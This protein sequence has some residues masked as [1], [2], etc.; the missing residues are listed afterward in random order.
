M[1]TVWNQ[2]PLGVLGPA[3]TCRGCDHSLWR[4]GERWADSAG[5]EVCIKVRLEDAGHGQ[6]PDYVFHQPLPAGLR[7]AP[8]G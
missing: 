3:A 6:R 2:D 7:G 4:R 5:V 8:T 1:A